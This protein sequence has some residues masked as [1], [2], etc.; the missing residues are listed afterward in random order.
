M[1]KR[2]LFAG[3]AAAP[4]A[5]LLGGLRG[6]KAAKPGRAEETEEDK[7]AARAEDEEDKDPA[8]EVEDPAEPPPSDEVAEDE[9]EDKEARRARRG[10]ADDEEDETCAEEDDDD[11]KVAAAARAGRKAE[12]TRCARIFGCQAAGLRPDVAAQ[13]AFETTMSSA[14]A[15]G[16]LNAVAAGHKPASAAKPGLHDRMARVRQPDTGSDAPAAERP[17]GPKGQAAAILAAVNKARPVG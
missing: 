16:V 1:T 12:R 14:E 7:D 6:P 13:L 15:I 4:F 3:G 17:S 2:T 9:N 5:H 10:R 8:A 11:D